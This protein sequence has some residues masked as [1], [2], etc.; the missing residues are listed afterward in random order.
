M[1]TEFEEKLRH[2]INF[3]SKE[4]GSNSPDFILAEYLSGCLEAFDRAVEQRDEW[5]AFSPQIV[6]SAPA[7]TALSVP[8][9]PH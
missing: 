1:M 7:A 2:A 8:A 3:C 9:A 4:N 5:H 6:S